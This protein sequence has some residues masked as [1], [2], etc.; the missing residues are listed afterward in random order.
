MKVIGPNIIPEVG[1]EYIHVP[2]GRKYEVIGIGKMKH[3]YGGH[4]IPSVTYK[5]LY[6]VPDEQAADI[7]T[8]E[9]SSFQTHFADADGIVEV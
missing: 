7:Y 3:P 6:E 5:P 4:W 9:L 8:R 1:N 2:T